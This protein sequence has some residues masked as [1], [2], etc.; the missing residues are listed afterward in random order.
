MFSNENKWTATVGWGG[1]EG[2]VLSAICWLLKVDHLDFA[3]VQ[4]M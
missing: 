3:E 1:G 4:L 2:E